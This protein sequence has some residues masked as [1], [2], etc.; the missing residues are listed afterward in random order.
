MK[1]QVSPPVF[2][3]APP[4]ETAIA[5]VSKAQWKP[6]GVQAEPVSADVEE[7]T[8][9]SIFFFSPAIC[10]T[11]SATEELPRSVIMST[12]LGV[13]PAASDGGGEIGLVLVIGAD[14]L[15]L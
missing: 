5:C 6:W 4:V 15:D 10:C 8:T 14:Q 1:Y 2:T 12:P 7:P 11:A 9:I 13:V 3:S